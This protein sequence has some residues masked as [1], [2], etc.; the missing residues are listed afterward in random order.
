MAPD[1]GLLPSGRAAVLLVVWLLAAA[2]VAPAFVGGRPA[3]EIPVEEAPA[4]ANLADPTAPAWADVPSVDV[5]LTSAPSTVPGADRT[6]V[7]ELHVSAA[8]GADTLYVRVT[9]PDGTRDVSAD[10]PRRFADGVAVQLPV[11]V[12]ERPAIAMGSPRSLV[13]VWYWSGATGGQELLAGGPGTTT[14]LSNAS[15][16]TEATHQEGSWSVVFVRELATGADNR[17]SI[18]GEEDVDV[19]FAVWNGSNGERSGRKAVSEWHYLAVGPGPQGPPYAALLWTVAG[20]A[21]VIV[22]LVTGHA[23]RRYRGGEEGAGPA[24]GRSGGGGGGR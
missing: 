20:L 10:D 11:N 21:M 16:R 2:V 18:T 15:V 1:G 3:N 8:T 24:G 19:A 6:S 5:P 23:V 12:S 14:S 7:T 17:T 4:G 22:V 9:W 13:N